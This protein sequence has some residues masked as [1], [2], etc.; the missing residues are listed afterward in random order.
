[1]AD[2]SILQHFFLARRLSW[3]M[4][5]SLSLHAS[6]IATLLYAS[7]H[8]VRPQ[9][10]SQPGPINAIM[11]NPAM[12]AM[13]GAAASALPGASSSTSGETT[14][15][16]PPA[17][18]AQQKTMPPEQDARPEKT[19][20]NAS[21]APTRTVSPASTRP[22]SVPRAAPALE[23]PKPQ[24]Q[25]RAHRSAPPSVVAPAKASPHETQ[26]NTPRPAVS[27]PQ[28]A[29]LTSAPPSSRAGAMTSAD[30]A[31]QSGASGGGTPGATANNHAAAPQAISRREPEYPA[32]ALALHVEGRVNVSFD[33]DGEGRVDNV[34]I[35][36][37][38]PAGV[39]EREVKRAVRRWRYQAGRPGHDVRVTV[40]FRIDGRSTI[41]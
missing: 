33:V 15:A 26:P 31:P 6:L 37:A 29:A 19:P 7:Y 27:A 18:Q 3:P 35:V 40:Y 8:E 34:R 39:F 28:A 36:S 24:R 13:A 14:A 2:K 4:A 9:P 1:M 16:T 32:R 21:P 38:D 10:V 17:P 5:L 23:K 11:V 41:E 30:Q 20:V 12:F 25:E 22:E